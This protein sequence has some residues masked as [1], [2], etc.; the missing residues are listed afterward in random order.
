MK[1]T[2][3]DHKTRGTKKMKD[4]IRKTGHE[5]LNQRGQTGKRS[6]E[7]TRTIRNTQGKKETIKQ[8]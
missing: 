8:F 5:R 2:R 4:H 1:K 3:Q 7:M 6:Q